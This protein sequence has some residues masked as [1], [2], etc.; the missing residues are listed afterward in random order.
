MAAQAQVI[1]LT[2][3][4]GAGKSRLAH[5]LH[6]AYGW[7]IVR[8]DD[9]YRD[10]DE[11]KLP[12]VSLGGEPITDWDH[13]GSWNAADAIAALAAL[14]TVGEAEVPRYDIAQSRRVGTH[15]VLL[16]DA[17]IVIAEGIFAAEI[18]PDLRELGLLSRAFCVTHGRWGNAALRLVRDLKE[19][20]KSPVILLRR[21]LSLFRREPV[22][23]DRARGLG[24]ACLPPRRIE[25]EIARALGAS[26]SPAP[27][28]FGPLSDSAPDR[29][30][31]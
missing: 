23:V 12:Q 15:H 13:P 6:T 29:G 7:P 22:I 26:L 17:T 16:G 3:P 1:L 20:R 24:A 19:H 21:G 14:V 11:P 10:G 31:R 9:F 25:T 18:A 30:P 28:T 2:G 5:R 8:L 4:S 27:D